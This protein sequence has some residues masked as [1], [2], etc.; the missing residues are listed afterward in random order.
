[1]PKDKETAP[2]IIAWNQVRQG[3]NDDSMLEFPE[4]EFPDEND[5]SLDMLF[6]DATTKTTGEK[7]MSPARGKMGRRQNCWEFKK[8]G[9]EPG[10]AKASELGVCPAATDASSDGLK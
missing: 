2:E 3:M 5:L 10:G 4:E 6:S 9:R 1:M 7:G 8:C